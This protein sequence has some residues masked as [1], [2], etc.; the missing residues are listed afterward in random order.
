M[1]SGAGLDLFLA[2]QRVAP[3][4]KAIGVD[5]T[6]ENTRPADFIASLILSAR[7]PA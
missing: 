3:E 5:M 4:G 1:D 6:P 2:A 7:K